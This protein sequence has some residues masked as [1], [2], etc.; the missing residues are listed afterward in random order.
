MF[1]LWNRNGPRPSEN[2]YRNFFALLTFAA[3]AVVLLTKSPAALFAALAFGTLSRTAVRK[4]WRNPWFADF[5]PYSYR[6][7]REVPQEQEE[8]GEEENGRR[9]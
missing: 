7:P 9:R 3:F 2:F 1:G 6:K 5:I 8:E 4:G